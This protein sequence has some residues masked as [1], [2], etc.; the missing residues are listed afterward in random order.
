MQKGDFIQARAQDPWAG[1]ASSDPEKRLVTYLGAGGEGK[2]QGKFPMRFSC[3]KGDSPDPGGL[4]LV[5]L[6]LFFPLAKH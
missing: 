3:A 1:R 2:V 4:A 5:K 6:R